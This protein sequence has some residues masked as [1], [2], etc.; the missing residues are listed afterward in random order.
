MIRLH[1]CHE[2]RSMR[3][4]WLI[5]ELGAPFGLAVDPFNRSQ[6]KSE[7]LA[8]S[9]AG[10]VVAGCGRST[11]TTGRSGFAGS[12]RKKGALKLFDRD[13][14]PAWEVSA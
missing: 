4:P 13:D 12:L 10:G 7:Y 2:T 11:R 14:D 8:R 6:H 1:H 9:P 3:V 5:D